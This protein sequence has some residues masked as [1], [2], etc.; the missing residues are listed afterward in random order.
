MQAAYSGNE[1]KGSG[2]SMIY[3]SQPGPHDQRQADRTESEGP[4]KA[5]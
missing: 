5:T 3:I 4:K 1:K 2:D